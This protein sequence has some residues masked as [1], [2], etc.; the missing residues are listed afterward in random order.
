MTKYDQIALPLPRGSRDKDT[1]IGVRRPYKKRGRAGGRRSSFPGT[2]LY[3]GPSMLTGDPIVVIMS[4]ESGNRKTDDIPQVWI[5]R[6]DMHPSDARRTG[7]DRAIC[8]GC[9]LGQN[10]GCYVPLDVVS[11][12]WRAYGNGSYTPWEDHGERLFRK[13]APRTVR[14]GAYGDPVAV[15]MSVWRRLKQAMKRTDRLLSYTHQWRLPQADEY[16]SFCMASVDSPAE[17]RLARSMGWRTFRITLPGKLDLAREQIGCPYANN[18]EITCKRCRLCAG[19]D[20]KAKSIAA[21]AH[22]HATALRAVLKLLNR[23]DQE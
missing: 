7:M 16:K 15:P 13:Q 12:V 8:G 23:K 4:F 14:I 9:E 2:I 21:E 20:V 3:E 18:Q 22:G 5:I 17:G 10:L 11:S 6:S 19:T 1:V